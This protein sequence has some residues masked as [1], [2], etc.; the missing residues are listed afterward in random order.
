[1]YQQVQLEPSSE[2][3]T[4]L[5]KPDN[6][7][8]SP[9]LPIEK[10]QL[11][12]DKAT[13]YHFYRSSRPKPDV[14]L[15]VAVHGIR[16]QAKL[17]ARLFAPFV[18]SIGGALVAPVFNRKRYADYQRLGRHGLGQRSDLALK[19]ILDEVGR[20]TGIS[21]RSVVMFGY[22]G[23]GQFVHRF[24]MAYP[25]QVLRMAIAAPGWY[26]FPDRRF[27]YPEGIGSCKD[28]PD[29]F[30]D[31]GRFLQI[32]TMVLVGEH[33]C[34]RDQN[35]NQS[36]KLDTSQGKNRIERARRW[37]RAME[38]AAAQYNYETE[39]EF[40]IVPGCGHSFEE[41]MMDG[42]MGRRVIDFLYNDLFEPV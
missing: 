38:A 3:Q 9:I 21:N 33:D 12:S 29:I 28:L 32:P 4:D 17:Q 25:R 2:Q 40:R 18:E 19:R 39:I 10:K 7:D 27:R 35:L 24:A 6:E 5:R 30:L 8:R 14:P 41:C 1:M 26:T 11:I 23:G 37:V 20:M 36:G 13:A 34:T 16:R 42:Q 15:M 31:P 22:S